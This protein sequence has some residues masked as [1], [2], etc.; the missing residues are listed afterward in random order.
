MGSNGT[1]TT[2]GYG[3]GANGRFIA[4]NGYGGGSPVAKRMH[5]FWQAMLEAGDAETQEGIFR[6]IG[7]LAP[8]RGHDR[9][10]ALH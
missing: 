9:C 8:G 3:R 6:K 1:V 5:E 2:V 10:K 4:G 7:E